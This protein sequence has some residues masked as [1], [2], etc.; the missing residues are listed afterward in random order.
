MLFYGD[1]LQRLQWSQPPTNLRAQHHTLEEIQQV[2]NEDWSKRRCILCQEMVISND[3][4]SC[5]ISFANDTG[6]V[7]SI[8]AKTVRIYTA[9]G[10]ATIIVVVTSLLIIADLLMTMMYRYMV[11][12]EGRVSVRTLTS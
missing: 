4:Y 11:A 8:L 10:L 9:L 3:I 1:T 5:W 12:M 6:I 7:I 2:L